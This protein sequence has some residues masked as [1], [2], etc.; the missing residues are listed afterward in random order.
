MNNINIVAGDLIGEYVDN[1]NTDYG[2]IT[3]T[4][5]SG[6]VIITGGNIK[7]VAENIE[8]IQNILESLD[9]IKNSYEY[10][11]TAVNAAT[12]AN[13][14]LVQSTNIR[15]EVLLEKERIIEETNNQLQKL[16]IFH[17][18]L[19]QDIA[20]FTEDKKAELNE[21]AG[22]YYIPSLDSEGNLS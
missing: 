8:A 22:T 9:D 21:I 20:D 15:D 19:S 5:D 17:S 2:S 11:S 1:G 3:D 10:A 6:T 7:T 12:E 14:Y 18:A 13:T 4:V 16:S